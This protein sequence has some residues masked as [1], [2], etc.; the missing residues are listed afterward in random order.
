F[1]GICLHALGEE[2]SLDESLKLEAA[3][4]KYK[5]LR[6]KRKADVQAWVQAHRSYWLVYARGYGKRVPGVSEDKAKQ[7]AE[8]KRGGLKWELDS[9]QPVDCF[10]PF[11]RAGI[12]TGMRK[13]LL[14]PL[15]LVGCGVNNPGTVPPPVTKPTQQQPQPL[16]CD[17]HEAPK[18]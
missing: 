15:V 7:M 12:P 16:R 14:A 1:Q 10:V 13:P 4:E 2:A 8:G 9:V 17:M 18:T 11:P 6:K 5:R 3:D